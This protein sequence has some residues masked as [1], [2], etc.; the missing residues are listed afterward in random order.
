MGRS[1]L[2][3]LNEKDEFDDIDLLEPYPVCEKCG[4]EIRSKRKR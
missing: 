2:V 1:I 4:Q 3:K